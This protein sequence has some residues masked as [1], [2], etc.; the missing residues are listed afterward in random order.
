MASSAKLVRLKSQVL[1]VVSAI[2][3]GLVSTYGTIG[4]HLGVSPRQ[5]AFVLAALTE[6]ES[7]GL[8]WFRVVADKGDVSAIKVGADA[9]T[10]IRQLR[11][12]GHAVNSR[13]QIEDIDLISWSAI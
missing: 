4:R 12:E 6:E 13:N 8:P 3:D 2:P 1:A 7:K 9:R 11:A 5:V 10:Q